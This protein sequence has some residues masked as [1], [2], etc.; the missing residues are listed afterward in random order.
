MENVYIK[1]LLISSQDGADYAKQDNQN[2]LKKYV[3]ILHESP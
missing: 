2:F 1:H 3:S